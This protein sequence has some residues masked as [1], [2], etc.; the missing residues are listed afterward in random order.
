M[1]FKYLILVR[2]FLHLKLAQMLLEVVRNTQ[3]KFGKRSCIILG[4]LWFLVL[5]ENQFRPLYHSTWY[6][7]ILF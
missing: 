2:F 6:N 4:C 7:Y 1:V 5:A 3:V